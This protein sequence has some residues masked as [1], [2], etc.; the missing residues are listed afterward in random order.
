MDLRFAGSLKILVGIAELLVNHKP[1]SGQNP[2]AN[3]L[4]CPDSFPPTVFGSG[5]FGKPHVFSTVHHIG[6]IGKK[7]GFC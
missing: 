6:T 3:H 2:W 7:A 5:D 4:T 1:H